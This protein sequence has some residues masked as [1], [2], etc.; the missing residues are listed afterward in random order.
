MPVEK[1]VT[2]LREKRVFNFSLLKLTAKLKTLSL[3]VGLLGGLTS[4]NL[5]R[6]LLNL[7]LTSVADDVRYAVAV[8]LDGALLG[9]LSDEVGSSLV[10]LGLL[11]HLFKLPLDDLDVLG[12]LLDLLFVHVLIYLTSLLGV[13]LLAHVSLGAAPLASWLEDMNTSALGG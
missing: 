4:S 5:L 12:H 11:F 9:P 3:S 7:H 13:E 10:I 8:E 2:S 1:S 6:H